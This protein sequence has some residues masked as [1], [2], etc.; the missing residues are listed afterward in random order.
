MLLANQISFRSGKS[1]VGGV[2]CEKV[3]VMQGGSSVTEACITDAK[4]L[5]ISA[6]DFDAVMSMYALMGRVSSTMRSGPG[7][8]FLG[9]LDGIPV[10][11]RDPEDGSV[12]SL[13]AVSTDDLDEKIFKV[14]STYSRQSMNQPGSY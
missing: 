2:S 9:A 7:K 11:L 8:D 13:K 1:K 5:G 4:T 3:T 10:M 6:A 12:R 14:P